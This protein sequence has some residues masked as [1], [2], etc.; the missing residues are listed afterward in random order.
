M[1]VA[2]VGAHGVGKTTLATALAKELEWRLIP[3]TAAE[4][5]HKGFAVN[6]DTPVENQFWILCKHL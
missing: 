6:E 5:F 4:A 2:I 3:D 1:K